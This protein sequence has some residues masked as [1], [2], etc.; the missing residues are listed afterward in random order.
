[1]KTIIKYKHYFIISYENRWK[2]AWYTKKLR[3]LKPFYYGVNAKKPTQ[4]GHRE[5]FIN[6]FGFWFHFQYK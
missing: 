4:T 3:L 6:L 2:R 5:F 1:M